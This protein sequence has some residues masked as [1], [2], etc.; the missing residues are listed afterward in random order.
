ME[1]VRVNVFG[2]FACPWVYNTAVWL[3][4]VKQRYQDDLQITWKNFS[5]EQN[6]FTLKQKENDESSEWKVW[7]EPDIAK[8]RSLQAALAGEAARR[9]G[10][11]LHSQFHLALLIARH[12]GETRIPLNDPGPICE[13][14]E[15]V[16]LD[17]ARFRKDLEDPAL[18]EKVGRDHQEA[19]A[20]GIFGTPT[21]VFENGNVAFLKAFL[22]PP[23][24][25]VSEFEHFVAIASHRNY[26]GELKRPQPPWPKG[27]LD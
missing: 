5:L 14:A 1:K 6:A 16:G 8:C 12:G 7:E 15:K 26:I 21:Y 17:M 9:Q 13:V 24:D 22:P 10:G 27:A 3:D 23:E 2:D 20:L 11:E 4:R 25:A 18:R 19:V